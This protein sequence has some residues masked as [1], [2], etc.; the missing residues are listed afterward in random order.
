MKLVRLVGFTTKIFFVRLIAVPG[1]SI[2]II[3]TRTT[4][5]IFISDVHVRP[6]RLAS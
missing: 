4:T 3:A 2:N 5:A 6:Q 1:S